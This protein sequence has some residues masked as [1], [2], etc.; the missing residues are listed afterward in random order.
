MNETRM[1]REL[2]HSGTHGI[3]FLHKIRTHTSKSGL[4]HIQYAP[5]RE[6]KD[7]DPL[8]RAPLLAPTATLQLYIHEQPQI[9][10]RVFVLSMFVAEYL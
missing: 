1:K 7:Y 5:Y 2:E 4:F 10:Q 6:P 9:F 3:C 8:V